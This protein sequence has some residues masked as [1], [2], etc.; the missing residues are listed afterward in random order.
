MATTASLAAVNVADATHEPIEGWL[1]AAQAGDRP[2]LE[3]FLEA[4]EQRVY[5]LAWRLVGDRALAEDVS[6]EA[7]LKIC[8]NLGQ[9]TPGTNLWGWIYRIVVNQAHDVRRRRSARHEVEEEIEIPEAA[10]YDPVR[11]EQIRRVME[12][13]CVL[14]PKERHALVLIDIEGFTSG[15]AA[16]VL[17]CLAITARTRAAQA[18]RKVRRELCRYYP[19]LE[20]QL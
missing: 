15:E 5:T 13:M 18:R 3:F 1:A 10:A 11:R 19:E 9:F 14:T 4:I 7:L 17:G 8:R 20:E 12:A 2:A 6:Q 16:K